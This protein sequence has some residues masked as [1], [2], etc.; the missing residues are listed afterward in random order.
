MTNEADII[1]HLLEVE[2]E[3][4]QMLL[5]AQKEAD[6][7]IAR[8]HA[9]AEDK[10]HSEY[11]RISAGIED[12]ENAR[13]EKIAAGHRADLDNYIKSLESGA[14]DRSAFDSLFESYL[15]S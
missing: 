4:S 1:R 2:R 7:D 5:D 13:K 15:F 12:D 8:A 10:F 3:A 6:G 14:R 9:E 11:V